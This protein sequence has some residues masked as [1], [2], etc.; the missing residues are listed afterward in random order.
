MP[1][2]ALNVKKNCQ[3]IKYFNLKFDKDAYFVY[4]NYFNTV[5]IF[6]TLLLAF[7]ICKITSLD[8]KISKILLRILNIRKTCQNFIIINL[9]FNRKSRSQLCESFRHPKVVK[10]CFRLSKLVK[11]CLKVSKF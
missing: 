6:L 5:F 7:I 1:P 11:C 8:F 4:K 2:H 10:I 9:K 3:N